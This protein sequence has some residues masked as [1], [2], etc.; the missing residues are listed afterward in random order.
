MTVRH[1]SLQRTLVFL[2][3]L[4]CAL[5][6][7]GAVQAQKA[8]ELTEENFEHDTQAT[9][10]STTGDW[11]ILF[12][13]YERFK[14]CRD[15]QPF[16]D[17]LSGLLRGKTSVAYIDVNKETRMRHRFDILYG[18]TPHIV[19][20]HRGHTYKFTGD[21]HSQD[22]LVDFAI[23]TFHD[24]EHKHKVPI[25]PTLL[26]EFRDM[27]NFN[28]VHK[29]GLVGGLLMQGDDGSVSY[30]ALFSVYILPVIIVVAFYYM[31]EAAYS[32][33]PDTKERT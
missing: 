31:M 33:D 32:T 28:V 13:E 22:A 14:K 9:T 30:M 16:W 11:L 17:E 21:I 27:F 29:N 4:L 26:E 20:L 18:Q 19:M 1:S 3:A 25:L 6:L 10:G 12:C 23:E 8:I 24:S 2:S 5:N 7:P 15:Y